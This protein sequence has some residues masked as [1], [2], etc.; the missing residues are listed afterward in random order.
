ML[1]RTISVRFMASPLEAFHG[2]EVG[3]AQC[4]IGA[5]EERDDGEGG[6]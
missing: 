3:G 2:A 1:W 6:E 5:G 4:G